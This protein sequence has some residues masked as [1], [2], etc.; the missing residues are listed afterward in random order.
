MKSLELYRNAVQATI[1]RRL[2]L[3]R[4][5]NLFRQ[6][7]KFNSHWSNMMGL[8]TRAAPSIQHDDGS[9]GFVLGVHDMG[10]V[11]LL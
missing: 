5:S 1:E 9:M 3:P 4:S 8:S 6:Q 2:S 7:T 10:S 11:D